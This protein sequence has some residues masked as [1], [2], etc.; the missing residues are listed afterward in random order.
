MIYQFKKTMM[1]VIL[2]ISV[3]MTVTGCTIKSD[4]LDETSIEMSVDYGLPFLID[5]MKGTYASYNHNRDKIDNDFIVIGDGISHYSSSSTSI[6]TKKE[7]ISASYNNTE[8]I[9]T[10]E[11]KD[12]KYR[13][14]YYLDGYKLIRLVLDNSY[15]RTISGK[16]IYQYE[17]IR[18][19]ND[20]VFLNQPSIGMTPDEVENSTWG[21]PD[22]IHA[23][24]DGDKNMIQWIYHYKYK[25]RYIYFENGYVIAIEY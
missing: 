25:N 20:S 4:R 14:I 23:M 15:G 13:F 10:I 5:S 9:A 6:Q 22:E 2:I 7:L 3:A 21:E 24:Q 19:S 11:S 18:I 1:S 16:P 8:C 17:Y 12:S